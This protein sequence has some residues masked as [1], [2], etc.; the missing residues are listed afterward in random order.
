MFLCVCVC[1][2][3]IKGLFTLIT[4]A[5]FCHPKLADNTCIFIYHIQNVNSR[6]RHVLG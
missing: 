3:I 2:A 4:F 5:I 1:V 6:K